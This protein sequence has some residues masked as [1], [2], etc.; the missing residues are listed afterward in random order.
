MIDDPAVAGLV[1]GENAAPTAPVEFKSSIA[2]TGTRL[3][4]LSQ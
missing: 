4:R 2:K 1:I 3:Q